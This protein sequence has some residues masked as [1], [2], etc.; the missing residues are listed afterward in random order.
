MQTITDPI[1]AQCTMPGHG[2]A[3]APQAC[4]RP[5][6]ASA[7]APAAGAPSSFWRDRETWRRAARNTLSCLL[8]CS[9]GDIAAMALVPLWWP[10][11]SQAT[12]TVI[13][14]LAG[15]AS[16]LWLETLVL[17]WREGMRWPTAMRV[18]L[19]MSMLSMVAMELAM[20]VTD[21]LLMGGQ[22]MPITHL[23]YWLLWIPSLAVGFL[24]PLPYNYQQLRRHG[25]SCH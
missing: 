24:L 17:R 20:N 5:G 7:P 3:D 25:R 14:I 18:A 1:K 19:G 10:Q 12:L 15:L 13:A 2:R 11:V 21:W 6:A 22:R 16:S 9:I 8:G 23:G 4:C